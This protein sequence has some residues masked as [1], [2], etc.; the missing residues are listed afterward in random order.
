MPHSNEV[1]RSSR[2]SRKCSWRHVGQ[3]DIRAD[4]RAVCLGEE[5]RG[6]FTP[7]TG[8]VGLWKDMFRMQIHG[9][10][11]DEVTITLHASNSLVG[12]KW[13]KEK[14]LFPPDNWEVFL[15]LVRVATLHA[16]VTCCEYQEHVSPLG[17]TLV[18]FPLY[19]PRE[20]PLPVLYALINS[21]VYHRFLELSVVTYVPTV[22]SLCQIRGVTGSEGPVEWV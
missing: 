3:Q 9:L 10:L 19:T 8:W 6:H 2:L 15:S 17:V 11:T 21:D 12:H 14:G 18:T 1:F 4:I 20:D 22:P 7:G 16:S 13:I 5:W